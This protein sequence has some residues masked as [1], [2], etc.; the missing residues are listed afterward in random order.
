MRKKFIL[1]FCIFLLLAVQISESN[2]LPSGENTFTL[3]LEKGWNLFS[4]PIAES[5]GSFF[6]YDTDCRYTSPL[7]GY[8]N[9]NNRY[10]RAEN[11]QA[12]KGFWIRV[13]EDCSVTVKE[14]LTTAENAFADFAL[15]R[16]WNMIGGVPQK[17]NFADITGDCQVA[18]G[19]YWFNPMKNQWEI[20]ES[21]EPGKGYATGVSAACH[22]GAEERPPLLPS[23]TGKC[24]VLTKTGDPT[25]NLDIVFVP[26]NI[27]D[28]V[29]FRTKLNDHINAILSVEPFKSKRDRINFYFLNVTENFGLLDGTGDWVQTRTAALSACENVDEIIVMIPSSPLGYSTIGDHFSLS[30]IQDTWKTVHEFGHGFAGLGDTYVGI[31]RYNGTPDLRNEAVPTPNIDAGGC[32]KW[33][34]SNS[35]PYSSACTQITDEVECR[36]HERR[37]GQDNQWTC[38]DPLKC[39]VWLPYNDP[40]FGT[41]CVDFRS[42]RNIG[43]NCL[44]DSGCY[45]GANGQ[46][47]WRSVQRTEENDG[48]T[49]DSI[50]NNDQRLTYNFGAV[51]RQSLEDIFTCCYPESCTNFPLQKC[52]NLAGKY[53]AFKNC[54]VCKISGVCGNGVKEVNEECDGADFEGQSCQSKGFSSGTLKCD[55]QCKLDA[56]GCSNACNPSWS[57]GSWSA[58]SSARMQTRSCT[59]V[60]NCGATAG[61]PTEAQSCIPSAI[62]TCQSQSGTACEDYE[63]CDGSVLS[64][65]DTNKCCLGTCKLPES[66]DWRNRHGENWNTPIRNQGTAGNCFIFAAVG[67]M[68]AKINL[69][70]NSHLNIDLS[71]QRFA[72]CIN[73]YDE[74]FG[75]AKH[76]TY[77]GDCG[78]NIDALKLVASANEYCRIMLNGGLPDELCDPYVS[79]GTWPPY[80]DSTYIC[81]DVK[82]RSW[83]ISG[84]R[85]ILLAEDYSK[86]NGSIT[87]YLTLSNKEKEDIV[88][89]TLIE[90]GPLRA[91]LSSWGH[92]MALVGYDGFSDWKTVKSPVFGETCDAESDAC[93]KCNVSNLGQEKTIC[94]NNFYINDIVWSGQNRENLLFKRKCTY[95]GSTYFWNLTHAEVCPKQFICEA[96]KCTASALSASNLPQGYKELNGNNEIIEYDP[97]NGDTNWIFKNSWGGDDFIKTNISTDNIGWVTIVEAPISPP[98]DRNFWPNG[99]DGT[100][101]C[102]DKDNDGFCN[103]GISKAKPATCPSSCKPEEDWDDSNAS[104]GALGK[105]A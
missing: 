60:N 24:I 37:L 26:D 51:E 62:H 32:S 48:S 94:N 68:E 77:I 66:F 8:S 75:M 73:S 5:S 47:A 6:A 49:T 83:N 80:C 9:A 76:G 2:S 67:A 45:Y 31:I 44:G 21:M 59:D 82:S 1:I 92:G 69:F 14:P 104:I 34:Q 7:W 30:S 61:K 25:K 11:I 81:M 84:Y 56:S 35:G 90:E 19:P 39:C 98:K 72:D 27:R 36:H 40:F 65:D 105:Y 85:D 18:R 100:I 52:Q 71:E 23:D 57:C 101:K 54:D 50:M 42:N 63:V 78:L 58:C 22:F 16:G 53:N 79:R 70:Y 99:F 64:A 13:A 97:G 43:I 38:D 88:K 74:P 89:K 10:V 4:A 29:D 96:G 28:L 12:K 20:A 91:G 15:Q 3:Y 87:D 86:Y 41:R 95:D 93:F 102:T 46:I 103:W 17:A 33:C 55:S